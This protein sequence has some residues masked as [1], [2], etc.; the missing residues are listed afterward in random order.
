VTEPFKSRRVVFVEISYGLVFMQQKE[1]VAIP[2]K[3]SKELDLNLSNSKTEQFILHNPALKWIGIILLGGLLFSMYLLISRIVLYNADDASIIL[4]AQSMLHGNVIMHG[5]Y[6]PTDNFLTIDMPL[7]AIGLQLG[8]SLTALL[9]IVPS[10]LYT[11]VILCTGYL[12]STLLPQKQRLWSWLALL[13]ILAFP[14][15]YMVQ[16]LL[17]GPIHV[18]TLL[19]ALIGLIAYKHFLSG[20]RGKWFTLAILLVLMTLAMVGDPLVLVFLVLPLLLTECIQ[21]VAKRRIS[22][23]ENAAFFGTLLAIG[24]SHL[25]LW[26]LDL[27]GV[28]ILSNI[29]FKW[30]TLHGIVTNLQQA[31]KIVYYI[32]NAS[33]FTSG[34][35]SLSSLPILL[36]AIVITTFGIA[37]VFAVIYA[38]RLAIVKRGKNALFQ[39]EI[40]P[41]AKIIQISIWSSIGTVAAVIFSTLGGALGRRYLYPLLFLSEAGTFPFLFKFVNKH[42]IRIAIVLLLIAN[43]IP[44]SISLFQAPAGVPSEIQLLATLKEHHLTHGLGSYWVSAFVTVRSNEQVVIRQVIPHN[45]SLQPYLFLVD[46]QW[47]NPANLQ[48]ANFIAYRK[49][50]NISAYYNASVRTFGKPD[51]QYHVNGFTVLAWNTPLLTHVQ[52]GYSF[53]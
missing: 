39:A 29:S 20:A 48:Q 36:N 23:Q 4:E 53:R 50:D 38:I 45:G 10:L 17:V 6:M 7:Y 25:L 14:P 9:R 33:I 49:G 37:M 24:I 35:F 46:G 3:P 22:L 1:K 40:T 11:L 26:I 27:A 32:F 28:H 47:F 19:F 5:W 2:P 16:L 21:I 52:P 51:H 12:V 30:A 44:F 13:G 18:G 8:F 42:V 41:D 34:S 15:L 43:A 31:I